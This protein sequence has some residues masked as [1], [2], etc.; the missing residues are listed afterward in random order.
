MFFPGENLGEAF[1][2]VLLVKEL[3]IFKVV[4]GQKGKR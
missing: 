4:V 2:C 1:P 3:R